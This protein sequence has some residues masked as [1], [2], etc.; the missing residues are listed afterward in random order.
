MLAGPAISVPVPKLAYTDC[1]PMV[2][3]RQTSGRPGS[4][5]VLVELAITVLVQKRVCMVE[6]AGRC[7]RIQCLRC[8]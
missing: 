6:I 3:M 5:V 4:V 7:S 1:V 8:R 2:A